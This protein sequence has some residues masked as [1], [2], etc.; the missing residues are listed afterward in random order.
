MWRVL[1]TMVPSSLSRS[2]TLEERVLLR[3]SRPVPSLALIGITGIVATESETPEIVLV[4][5][6]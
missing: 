4:E 6:E 3:V 5:S 2:L 1:V